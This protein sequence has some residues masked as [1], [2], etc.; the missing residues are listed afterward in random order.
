[1]SNKP[2]VLDIVASLRDVPDQSIRR[3]MV[4]TVVEEKGEY[5]LVEFCNAE[6]E[7]LALVSLRSSDFLI[8]ER[9]SVRG[10]ASL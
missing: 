9:S 1:M 3:G 5:Y 8:L 4:G 10:I 6:G 2:K 7:T